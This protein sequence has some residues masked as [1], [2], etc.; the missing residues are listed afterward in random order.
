VSDTCI[1]LDS[2]RNFGGV[3]WDGCVSGDHLDVGG[4]KEVAAVVLHDVDK[5][6]FVLGQKYIF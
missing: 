5:A 2:Y 3:G 1:R 6:I 4:V